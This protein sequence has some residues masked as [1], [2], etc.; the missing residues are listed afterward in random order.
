MTHSVGIQ[1]FLP[2]LLAEQVQKENHDDLTSSEF[3]GA[4]LFPDISGFTQTVS[5]FE[6]MG[7][8][9][10]EI[11][12]NVVDK[13]FGSVAQ[14]ASYYEGDVL[15][16]AGD[17]V[18]ILW[19]ARKTDLKTATWQAAE[20]A[21]QIRD[22]L[23]DFSSESVRIQIRSYLSIGS[24]ESLVIPCG[25]NRRY[26][27][28]TGE[29]FLKIGKCRLRPESGEILLSEEA[30]RLLDGAC[31][32][33]E[34]GKGWRMLESVQ[35]LPAKEPQDLRQAIDDRSLRY[36]LPPLITRLASTKDKRWLSQFRQISTA[37][38][39]FDPEAISNAEVI[40]IMRIIDHWIEHLEG[41]V[42]G[43]RS[44]DKGIVVMAA[45]GLPHASTENDAERSCRATLEIKR[46]I[47]EAVGARLICKVGISTGMLFCGVLGSSERQDYAFIGNA[48][49]RAARLM[50]HANKDTLFDKFTVE[51]VQKKYPFRSAGEL[52]AREG[53][54]PIPCFVI[55]DEANRRAEVEDEA[56]FRIIGRETELALFDK[57]LQALL[58]RQSSEVLWFE[59]EPGIGK[60]RLLGEFVAQARAANVVVL[61]GHGDS[62]DARTPYHIWRKILESHVDPGNNLTSD[63]LQASV[64][65]QL[66]TDL[67]AHADLLNDLLP[68]DLEAS[69]ISALMDSATRADVIAKLVAELLCRSDDD[70]PLVLI[71]DDCHW[72]DSASWG[73]IRRVRKLNPKI[74]ILLAGRPIE[75]P[76][77]DALEVRNDRATQITE[78]SP[79]TDQQVHHLA[80]QLL[81]AEHIPD[82]VLSLLDERCAGN[83]F[84]CEELIFS[85]LDQGILQV[86][87]GRCT[88][89]GDLRANRLP[90]SL[91]ALINSRVDMLSP[92]DQILLKVCSV[93]GQTFS[94]SMLIDVARSIIGATPLDRHLK[95][96]V[97]VKLIVPT[98]EGKQSDFAF[99]HALGRD[100]IYQQMTT[101]QR[102]DLHNA[103]AN[104]Y[105]RNAANTG[106]TILPI[107]AHHWLNADV[108]SKAVD[109]LAQAGS[110]ALNQHANAEAI[111]F[112]T[113]ALE[114][115]TTI[116]LHDRETCAEWH[117]LLAEAHLKLSNFKD[118]KA[119]LL[120]A[121]DLLGHGTPTSRFG[122]LLRAPITALSA[123]GF[124][125]TEE[126]NG[127]QRLTCIAQLHQQ[128]AEVAFFNHDIASLIDATTQCI[129]VAR[130]VGPTAEL[131][132]AL[133]TSGIVCG[134][135]GLKSI[136][137]RHCQDSINVACKVGHLPTQAY[138]H[139]LASVYYNSIG[140]WLQAEATIQEAIAIY[141][142]LRDSYRWQSCQMINAY[143]YMHQGKFDLIDPFVQRVRVLAF[144]DGI[145]QVRA[146]CASL[147]L[148]SQ[149]LSK[150]FRTDLIEDAEQAIADGI[151]FS[152]EVLVRGALARAACVGGDYLRAADH[153][154]QS[155]AMI[156][157]RLP[158]TYHTLAGMWST[159]EA[160]LAL[161]SLAQ[162]DSADN[163]RRA[164]RL[165][166][167]SCVQLQRFARRVPIARAR[168][169][170]LRGHLELLNGRRKR[171]RR[172]WHRSLNQAESD[173]MAEEVMLAN[174][175]L[176]E[177]P[178]SPELCHA[179]MDRCLLSRNHFEWNRSY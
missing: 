10:I 99:R 23:A 12:A 172:Y 178:S 88:F 158:P 76:S 111:E 19:D 8:A 95:R 133:G 175:S 75:H 1:R 114:I 68:L 125:P 112:L 173:R 15:S 39:Q 56:T 71:L 31:N 122:L 159:T 62:I 64:L 167:R 155:I 32:A 146:W 11:C 150:D 169:N 18:V 41:C 113:K 163:V 40:D 36:F 101:E 152:E 16:F 156:Q 136:A 69:K 85:M 120:I 153:V 89:R 25:K 14:T 50:E 55:D 21:I 121:L 161:A 141:S 58:S 30:F 144:P 42:F 117:R 67:R 63:R 86:D 49:N 148:L 127:E 165:A 79:L 7:E 134:V 46:E 171:A 119:N 81:C 116:R 24:I 83:P 104:W 92:Q 93:F 17:A 2:R 4:I 123:W 74:L 22:C 179:R 84:F 45:F 147:E 157:E 102:T 106:D 59:G 151:D 107:L 6:V 73:L 145:A 176:S 98:D 60:S 129:I 126:R 38:F 164:F 82:V 20:C 90:V 139:Q 149:P 44:D 51:A 160:S 140:N 124:K 100:V 130:A 128:R 87:R 61:R 26:H 78:I 52:K 137:D 91:Q 80:A 109:Y 132:R 174:A 108:P 33:R 65:P 54:P 166:K 118:C 94:R 27:F 9:G 96:C 34:M 131:A 135:L 72:I 35:P 168:A 105:E 154:E 110:A 53:E 142:Q 37:F 103:A 29:P 170:Y 48:V 115:E 70:W 3:S 97:D 5:R 138:V 13:Y 43:I 77:E 57:E 177:D 28:V 47:S 162:R 143:Q 66:G